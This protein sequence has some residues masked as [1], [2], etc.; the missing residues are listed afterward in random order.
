MGVKEQFGRNVHDNHAC[1]SLIHSGDWRCQAESGVVGLVLIRGKKRFNLG[2][3]ERH[4]FLKQ[5]MPDCLFILG[6][7]SEFKRGGDDRC[8]WVFAGRHGITAP[9][10]VK[11]LVAIG[12]EQS[13][14]EDYRIV[15]YL[16]DKQVHE[17]PAPGRVHGQGDESCGHGGGRRLEKALS[18]AFHPGVEGNEVA[19]SSGGGSFFFNRLMLVDVGPEID[20]DQSENGQNA[21]GKEDDEDYG[22]QSHGVLW[23]AF[24]LR[25]G[26]HTVSLAAR[27]TFFKG[28]IVS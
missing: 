20:S 16:A 23:P 15:A 1:H 7:R 22:P 8:Q 3:L 26:W 18:D 28:G 21:K 6:V 24:V 19:F 2:F 12:V 27:E 13:D 4:P 10:Q 14:T 9:A 5:R 25:K 17:P 11:Q